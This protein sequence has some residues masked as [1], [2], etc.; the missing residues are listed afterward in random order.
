MQSV[1][2]APASETLPAGFVCWADGNQPNKVP[3]APLVF[4]VSP[5]ATAFFWREDTACY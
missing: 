5:Q 1:I 4:K 2:H 3:S